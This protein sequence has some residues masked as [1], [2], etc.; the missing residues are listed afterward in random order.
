[1]NAK[2]ILKLTIYLNIISTNRN[3]DVTVIGMPSPIIQNKLTLVLIILL[4]L[5]K[6]LH[7]K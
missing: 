5:F 3:L 4:Q 1:M 2:Q 6:A 7:T